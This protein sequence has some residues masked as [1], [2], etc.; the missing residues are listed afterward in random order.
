MNVWDILTGAG[1]G[2]A[3]GVGAFVGAT[4]ATLR[5]IRE[6]LERI[7]RNLEKMNGTVDE[8]R[9]RISFLEAT[10]TSLPPPTP[11]M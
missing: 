6:A 10:L 9:E 11:P 2:G 7:D 3:L 4:R 1:A 5:S 8:H